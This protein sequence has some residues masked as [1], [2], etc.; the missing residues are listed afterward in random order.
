MPTI[1]TDEQG[2]QLKYENA[3]ARIWVRPDSGGVPL[4]V[5]FQVYRQR[6]WGTARVDLVE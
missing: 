3:R 6:Q 2:D 4:K 1:R 5:V